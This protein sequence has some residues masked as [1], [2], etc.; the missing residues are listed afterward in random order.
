L[1]AGYG[2]NLTFPYD[3]KIRGQLVQQ[4]EI[5]KIVLLI[6][7][8]TIDNLYVFLYN[9]IQIKNELTIINIHI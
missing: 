2:V 5:Y 6:F 1:D 7:E 9:K 4:N 8:F 3:L